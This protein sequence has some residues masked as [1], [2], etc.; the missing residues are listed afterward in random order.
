MQVISRGSCVGLR[1]AGRH[2]RIFLLSRGILLSF[3]S[4]TPGALLPLFCWL[5]LPGLLSVHNP[6]A[7]RCR[8]TSPLRQTQRSTSTA[9]FPV[10]RCCHAMAGAL[11]SLLVLGKTRP[12]F[13]FRRWTALS[14]RSWMAPKELL[15]LFG[16]QMENSSGSSPMENSERFLLLGAQS[17]YLLMLPVAE[18]PHGA[19]A[20]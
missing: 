4:G 8:R 12:S 18:A 15:S 9:T 16:H 11:S 14:L 2:R 5:Y 19:L 1:V 17:R 20:T 3:G 6:R 7:G 10:R 13:M